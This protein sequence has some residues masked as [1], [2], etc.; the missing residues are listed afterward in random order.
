MGRVFRILKKEWRPEVGYESVDQAT[1]DAFAFIR[2]YNFM[3]GHSYNNY[4]TP[5]EVEKAFK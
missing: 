4:A 1:T 5:A 2:Y 3:R